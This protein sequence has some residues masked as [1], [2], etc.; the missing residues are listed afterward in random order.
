MTLPP[1]P[2]RRP[3]GRIQRHVRPAKSGGM[4]ANS[5]PCTM[6]RVYDCACDDRQIAALAER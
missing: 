3:E 2:A 5:S 1:A 4:T 6:T